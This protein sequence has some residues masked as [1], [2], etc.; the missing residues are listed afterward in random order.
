AA[1]DL[2]DPV[3]ARKGQPVRLCRVGKRTVGVTAIPQ[4]L[5]LPL[6][7]GVIVDASRRGRAK[8][9]LFEDDSAASGKRLLIAGCDPGI[10]LLAQHMLRADV[11]MVIAP[12]SSRSA[13]G[14]LKDGS[15]HIAGSHLRDATGEFNLSAIER[16]FPKGGVTVVTFAIWEQG[17]A[18]RAGNP[19]AI[20][21]VGD[22]GRKNIRI[23]NREKGAGSRELL[24]RELKKAGI[25]SENVKGY[26]RVAPGHLPAALAVSLGEADCCVATR[27]AARA[28]E[29]EFLPLSAERY[30]LAIPRSYAKTPA[31]QT[32]LDVLN[33]AA[34]RR[35][36]EMLAGYDMSHT[37]EVRM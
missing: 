21:G 32:L 24:D 6:A 23:V 34:V 18:V 7:D 31:V 12:S 19:K 29:L 26:D 25:A 15:V 3:M 11:D 20:R 17:L 27:S 16:L 35:E 33:R 28:F 37:G 13:L 10:S 1:L 36:F 8:A 30:D 2:L 4:M 9:H 14:W 5:M 22:L